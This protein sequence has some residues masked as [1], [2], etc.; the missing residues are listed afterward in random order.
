MG[1]RMGTL[2]EAARTSGKAAPPMDGTVGERSAITWI[3]W[4]GW[5]ALSFPVTVLSHELA[6]FLSYVVFGFPGA[7]LHFSSSSYAVETALW[8]HMGDGDRAG[9]A[10]LLPLGRVGIAAILGPIVSALTIV[11]CVWLAKRKPH[12]FLLGLL[13]TVPLRSLA[14]VIVLFGLLLGRTRGGGSDEAHAA[15]LL[16]VPELLLHLLAVSLL[17]VAWTS[18]VKFLAV[19]TRTARLT[20]LFLGAAIGGLVYAVVIGPALLP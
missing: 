9:A 18:V 7:A 14:S 4:A 19:G 8:K 11:L 1:L 16:P 20:A 10:A 3:K 12:P 13:L 2:Y 5:A 15:A 17:V 6:H